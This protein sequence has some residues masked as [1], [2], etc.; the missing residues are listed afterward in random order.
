MNKIYNDTSLF[1]ANWT[2]N[3]LKAEAKAYDELIYGE[4]PCYGVRDIK[5]LD[6]I[7]NE[8]NERGINGINKLTFN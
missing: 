7:L 5:T 2:I 4:M 6:G 8:L 3:K 1:I